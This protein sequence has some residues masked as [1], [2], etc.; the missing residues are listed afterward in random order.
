M[1]LMELTELIEIDIFL[2]RAKQILLHFNRTILCKM[3]D[4]MVMLQ[5]LYDSSPSFLIFSVLTTVLHK[6]DLAP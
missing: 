4:N 5:F 1:V 6:L 2:D 3:S